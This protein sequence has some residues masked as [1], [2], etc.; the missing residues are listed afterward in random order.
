MS[1]KEKKKNNINNTTNDGKIV[2]RKVFEKYV[3]K[4]YSQG[5]KQGF[6]GP[7]GTWFRYDHDNYVR[8]MIYNKNSMMYN[9]FDYN[10]IVNRVNNHFS[11]SSN[12]RLL[13]WS[14]LNFE[15]WLKNFIKG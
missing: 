13:I 5:I 1:Y 12:D 9:Y 6:S 4:E 7:D 10:A 2:L 3:T 14:L 15:I 8:D 11:G